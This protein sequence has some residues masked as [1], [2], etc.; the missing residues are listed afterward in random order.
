MNCSPTGAKLRNTWCE[1]SEHEV[2]H[3]CTWGAAIYNISTFTPSFALLVRTLGRYFSTPVKKFLD[4]SQPFRFPT[5]LLIFFLASI[6]I[7]SY[8]YTYI[9]KYLHTQ[10]LQSLSSYI[11]KYLSILIHLYM[12]I[13][14]CKSLH[15][16][17]Y[18]NICI[19]W[20]ICLFAYIYCIK[21]LFISMFP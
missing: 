15:I 4:V 21:L 2:L 7:H 8:F 11:L 18:P 14:L 5:P 6:Y 19:A 10:V 9:S 13:S 1:C 12:N 20:N 3:S 17:Q 16:S